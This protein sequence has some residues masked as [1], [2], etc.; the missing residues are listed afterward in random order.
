MALDCMRFELE[1]DGAVAAG[2]KAFS[3]IPT[4][5]SRCLLALVDLR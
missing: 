5:I 2:F 4:T 3:R 1:K